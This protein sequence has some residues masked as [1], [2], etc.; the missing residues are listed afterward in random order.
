MVV[1]KTPSTTAAAATS[2][3]SGEGDEESVMAIQ[4]FWDSTNAE[5]RASDVKVPSGVKI[6]A[7][8]RGVVN[9][10]AVADTAKTPTTSRGRG[11]PPTAKTTPTGPT[12][13]A[14][15]RPG[16]PPGSTNKVSSSPRKMMAVEDEVNFDSSDGS[17]ADED[18]LRELTEVF[19]QE[20][21]EAKAEKM[22]GKMP[23][24]KKTA[25]AAAG[26]T[27]LVAVAEGAAKIIK[28]EVEDSPW[29]PPAQTVTP[30]GAKRRTT[31]ESEP[32]SS[33]LNR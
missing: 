32:S 22:N 17:D 2:T 23:A 14:V 33:E 7:A 12:T 1:D 25:A 3:P 16:R 30:G 20:G 4:K 13:T 9:V 28:K 29:D 11:R 19:E 5:E 15:R 24:A 31:S 26:G 27:P 10:R 6:T 21:K 8:G 18:A